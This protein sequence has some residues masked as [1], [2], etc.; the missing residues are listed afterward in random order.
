MLLGPRIRLAGEDTLDSIKQVLGNQRF[1]RALK[2]LASAPKPY[3]TN[4]ERVVENDRK[5][6]FTDPVSSS[7]SK[8]QAD[9][10]LAYIKNDACIRTMISRLSLSV[11]SFALGASLSSIA[12][13]LILPRRC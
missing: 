2:G 1:M 11:D 10:V 3:Q 7:V 8:A 4:V 9:A 5:A 13:S 12:L 6:V